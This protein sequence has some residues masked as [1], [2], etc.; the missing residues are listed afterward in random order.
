[1][2]E[3]TFREIVNELLDARRMCE[4]TSREYMGAA[5]LQPGSRQTTRVSREVLARFLAEYDA[6]VQLIGEG[7]ANVR[8]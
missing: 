6:M 8:R 7:A 2:Q 4:T 3:P 1:M 5:L